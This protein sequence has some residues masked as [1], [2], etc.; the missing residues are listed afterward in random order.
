MP[1]DGRARPRT[2]TGAGLLLALVLTAVLLTALPD[3]DSR[4]DTDACGPHTV[5]SWSA[6]D[7]LTAEFARYG[8]DA[9]RADDWTG[10]DG[11][12]SVRLPDGRVLWLFSDTYLGQVHGPPNPVGESFAWR[13]GSAPLVRNSPS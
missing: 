3:D 11:T 9:A 2:G 13:D 8:D 5:A 4:P 10:G 12:H 7:R 1:E 6:D